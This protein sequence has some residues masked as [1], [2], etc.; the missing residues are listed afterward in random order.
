[1]NGVAQANTD[2]YKDETKLSK[3][4]KRAA[5]CS[6]SGERSWGYPLSLSSGSVVNIV[7]VE[8]VVCKLN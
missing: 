6:S 5:A 8:Q 7:I 4:T 1:M 3:V 2:P